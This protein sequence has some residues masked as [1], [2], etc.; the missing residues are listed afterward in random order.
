MDRVDTSV[1]ITRFGPFEVRPD[2]RELYKFGTRIKIRPQPFLV[3]SLLIEH[4]GQVITRE[5]FQ[6]RLWPSDTFVDFEHSLNT[7][8]KELRGILSDSATEPRYIET[9]P[10]LGYRFIFPVERSEPASRPESA[11]EATILE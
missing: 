7:A 9:I 5:Q 3:L 6:Q 1:V 11:T 2:S 4:A 8:I 10:R